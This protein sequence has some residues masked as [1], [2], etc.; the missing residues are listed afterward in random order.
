MQKQFKQQSLNNDSS[1]S[2]T[3]KLR[4]A[5][6]SELSLHISSAATMTQRNL[7]KY[8]NTQV[9]Y[10]KVIL[11]WMYLSTNA[12]CALILHLSYGSAKNSKSLLVKTADLRSSLCPW[13][14]HTDCVTWFEHRVS[15]K[16]SDELMKYETWKTQK[17][18][19]IYICPL[20]GALELFHYH[21]EPAVWWVIKKRDNKTWHTVMLSHFI[22]HMDTSFL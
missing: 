18:E 16:K 6:Q 7:V 14:H 11:E 3:E 8:G 5:P 17:E 19:I 21:R 9:K 13:M 10:L 20:D 1:A 2:C 4:W 12:I 22:P 15:L